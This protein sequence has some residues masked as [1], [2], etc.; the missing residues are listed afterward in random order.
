VTLTQHQRGGRGDGW[1]I[2]AVDAGA[3]VIGWITKLVVVFAIIGVL[4]FDAISVGLG[5]TSTADDANNAV[6]AASQSYERSHDLQAAYTAAEAVIKPT[7]TI[8]TKD[9][10]IQ[11][12]G[13]TSLSVTNTAHT[14][15]LY[16]TSQTKGLAVVTVHATGL[17]TG[18]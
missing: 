13:T 4:G 8:G 6:Q 17:Y 7:E 10:T 2:D 15:V 12:D 11:P 18:S 16:R 14:L 1:G 5:Y 9:F 3:I